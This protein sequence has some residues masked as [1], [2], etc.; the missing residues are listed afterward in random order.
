MT[1]VLPPMATTSMMAN[2]AL[3]PSCCHQV[4]TRC[5]CWRRLVPLEEVGQTSSP[6]T[7]VAL[8]THEKLR[9][10]SAHHVTVVFS[11]SK[12]MMRCIPALL[13]RL[14]S[15]CFVKYCL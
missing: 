6:G 3:Q 9:T 15:I 1:M 10:Q 4:M 11:A 2:T 7:I 5:G 12:G 14:S 13:S 8:K